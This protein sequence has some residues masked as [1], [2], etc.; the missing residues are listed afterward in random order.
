MCT[1]NLWFGARIKTSSPRATIA[2]LRVNKYSHC[3]KR[4][5]FF[6][7]FLFCF[8]LFFVVV[9]LPYMGIT[10]ILVIYQ[11][12]GCNRIHRFIGPVNTYLCYYQE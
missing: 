4:F 2:H 5:F 10:A 11:V 7:F 8:V 12:Y 6:F 1:H 3:T 9:F